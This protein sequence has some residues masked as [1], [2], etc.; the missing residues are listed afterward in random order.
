M[1]SFFSKCWSGIKVAFT[2]GKKYAEEHPEQV[3]QVVE[4]GKTIIK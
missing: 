3:A 2:F 1:K 4:A